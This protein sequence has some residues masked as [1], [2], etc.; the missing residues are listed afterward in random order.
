MEL[1][2]RAPALPYQPSAPMINSITLSI[3]IYPNM[4]WACERINEGDTDLF[5][6][7]FIWWV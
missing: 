3:D 1:G 2:G 6:L 7:P 4:F 5:G